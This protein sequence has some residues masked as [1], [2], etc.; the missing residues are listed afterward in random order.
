MSDTPR[1]WLPF[2]LVALV[3]VWSFI[4]PHDRA[5]WWMEALPAVVGLPL[6]LVL[7]P[8]FPWTRLA[9]W[10][11]AVHALILL[12]GAH[13]TY[14][15]TP[16]GFWLQEAFDLSRNHY[17]RLGHLAQG[18]IP[19]ILA[20]EVLGRRLRLGRGWLLF[21]STCFCLAFSA[22]YELIEWA[23]ALAL[24]EGA[25]AFLATQGD[26]WDTQW[27]MF[28]ALTGALAAQGLLGHLHDRQLARM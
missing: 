18:F 19:A 2:G 14:A 27:D 6:V 11:M 5:T 20:R 17:D 10:L 26:P 24:G 28:L 7:W 1:P 16:L 23:A 25:D 21:L 13:Y 9:V 22:L 3:A 4:A 12:V 15:L 8:R